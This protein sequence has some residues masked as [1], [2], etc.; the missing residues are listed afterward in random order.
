[1]LKVGV[2]LKGRRSIRVSGFSDKLNRRRLCVLSLSNNLR[3]RR[4]I[5]VFGMSYQLNESKGVG[6]FGMRYQL[7]GKL[8]M[9]NCEHWHEH[10]LEE[11]KVCKR[12]KQNFKAMNLTRD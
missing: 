12:E 8:K 7:R 10:C 2:H 9:K 11:G 5:S 1:M 4:R 6:E 3:G